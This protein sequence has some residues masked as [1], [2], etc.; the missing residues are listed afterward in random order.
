V[1]VPI[2]NYAFAKMA[3]NIARAPLPSRLPFETRLID[4]VIDQGIIMICL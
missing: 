3:L 2:S 1:I 4:H